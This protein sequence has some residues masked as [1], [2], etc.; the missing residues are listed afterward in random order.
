M[1]V[2]MDIQEVE[3]ISNLIQSLN[4]LVRLSGHRTCYDCTHFSNNVCSLANGVTPPDHV[5]T[6][7]C[8]S[9]EINLA[10]F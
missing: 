2:R 6:K 1:K 7:G 4:K 5:L 8:N 3:R 9:F 10:P